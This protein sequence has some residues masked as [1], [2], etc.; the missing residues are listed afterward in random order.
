M[1]KL[2]LFSATI[3]FR[4][5]KR[6]FTVHLVCC[7]VEETNFNIRI[8]QLLC[9]GCIN[10]NTH[11]HKSLQNPS[12]T[13]FKTFIIPVFRLVMSVIWCIVKLMG[14]TRFLWP[15]A[16][17][18]THG[19]FS[20][21]I[22]KSTPNM[23]VFQYKVEHRSCGQLSTLPSTLIFLQAL[24]AVYILLVCQASG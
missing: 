3:A 23:T 1:K 14:S 4:G 8:A 17:W 9:A 11:K 24:W 15:T 12:F 16:M 21:T 7:I 13:I 18:I 22:L 2:N 10:S 6:D 5:I 19:F 20:H